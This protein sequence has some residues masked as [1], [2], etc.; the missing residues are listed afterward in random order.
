MVEIRWRPAILHHRVEDLP[1]LIKGKDAR[2][3]EVQTS[4]VI[5][6]SNCILQQYLT[7]ESVVEC[8]CAQRNYRPIAS[9]QHPDQ[10]YSRCKHTLEGLVP[11]KASERWGPCFVRRSQSCWRV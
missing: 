8:R 2:I 10:P 1:D 4:E 3:A 5:C 6:L 9:L 11:S 7:W